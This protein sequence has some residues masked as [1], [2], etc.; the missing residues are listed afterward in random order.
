MHVLPR[1]REL[2]R[3]F[4]DAL[5][6]I[7]VHAGK[8]AAERRTENIALAAD[9][10]DVHHAVVNDRQFRVWRSYAVQAWPTIA[11]VDPSGYLVGVQP[12]EFPIEAMAE[13][14]EELIAASERDGTLVRG[15]D[16]FYRPGSPTGRGDL[17]YPGR[18]I[19]AADRMAISDSGNGRVIVASYAAATSSATVMSSHEGFDEPQGLAFVGEDLFVAERRGHNVWRIGR[20]GERQLV[21]GT[22]RLAEGAIT[23]GRAS[24]ARLRSPWGLAA[25]ADGKLI[26]A[27]AGAHQLWRIDPVRDRL[28]LVAGTGGE[29]IVDGDAR[30]ALLAQPTGASC[31]NGRALFADSESSAVRVYDAATESVD[32]LTGT[33]LFDFGDRDGVGDDVLMQHVE[34]V[35]WHRGAVAAADTYNDRIKRVDPVTREAKPWPGAIGVAGSLAQPA[36]I[37][38]DGQTL[39]V[40]D[41]NNH[42]IVASGADG[43]MREVTLA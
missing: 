36:G 3:R 6:V 26:V 17:R 8:Y 43:E 23:V 33:G 1:V 4:S 11:L 29:D 41:T 31:A 10:L 12:G 32:T 14:I 13:A 39:Y 22:G 40:V 42:R 37:S 5:V 21:A 19:V 20:D 35:V 7:A 34:D 15:P 24:D 28:E 27:M 16:P 18:V 2:E 38:S 25:G 30:S 9:R